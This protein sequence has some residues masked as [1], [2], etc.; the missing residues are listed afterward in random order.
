M[1]VEPQMEVEPPTKKLCLVKSDSKEDLNSAMNCSIP[2]REGEDDGEMHMLLTLAPLFPDLDLDMLRDLIDLTGG[3]QQAAQFA[4]LRQADAA[5]LIG[6]MAEEAV[7]RRALAD[8]GVDV[9]QLIANARDANVPPPCAIEMA[10]GLIGAAAAAMQFPHLASDLSAAALGVLVAAEGGGEDGY[11]VAATLALRHKVWQCRNKEQVYHNYTR[12]QSEAAL[13]RWKLPPHVAESCGLPKQEGYTWL[14]AVEH[15]RA[16]ATKDAESPPSAIDLWKQMQCLP[17]FQYTQSRCQHCGSQSGNTRVVAPET[18]DEKN[19]RFNLEGRVYE[20]HCN[21]CGQKSRWWRSQAP[22]IMLNPNNW[23]RRCGECADMKVWFAGYLEV[24]Q[25]YVIS[26]DNDHI[27]TETWD[28]VAGQFIR[29][30]VHGNGWTDVIAIGS[31]LPGTG[32]SHEASSEQVTERYL[33]QWPDDHPVRARVTERRMDATGQKTQLH[34]VIGYAC[35]QGGLDAA[36]VTRI[37]R[38]AQRDYDARRDLCD[39]SDSFQKHKGG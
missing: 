18:E 29:G 30:G 38:V 1:E 31:S 34:S 36:G 23:G 16:L 13:R 19:P 12:E 28:D 6:R 9:D 10:L 15:K 4:P 21:S 7:T 37:L 8:R 5:A 32:P 39:I 33:K 17:M 22:E 27:W 3:V 20:L 11:R 25:R 24:G 2:N 14:D 35:M 26:V